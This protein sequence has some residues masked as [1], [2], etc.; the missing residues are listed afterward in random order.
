MAE[1]WR[2]LLGEAADAFIPGNAY[3]SDLGRWNRNTAIVGGVGALVGQHVPGGG[4]LTGMLARRG[5]FGDNIRQGLNYEA[6]RDSLSPSYRQW[7]AQQAE[8]LRNPYAPPNLNQNYV[9]GISHLFGG[10]PTG[11][12]LNPNAWA[13]GIMDRT[14]QQGGQQIHDRERMVSDDLNR[15]LGIT[16][17]APAR[18]H[19]GSANSAGVRGAIDGPAAQAMFGSLRD[20]QNAR[21][22]QWHQSQLDRRRS[23]IIE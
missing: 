21:A 8:A 15:R 1:F 23:Q 19:H 22:M 9:T 14:A 5:M 3:N 2:N 18:S 10:Q 4:H 11:G 6:A 12:P 17:A 16:D 7:R 13:D 20:S